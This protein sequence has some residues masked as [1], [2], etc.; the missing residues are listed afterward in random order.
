MDKTKVSDTQVMSVR[1]YK[2][3]THMAAVK[4]AVYLILL[5][6]LCSLGFPNMQSTFGFSDSVITVFQFVS[7]T[8]QLVGVLFCIVAIKGANK[9][10]VPAGSNRKSATEKMEDS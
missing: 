4:K 2:F 9:I 10:W 6:S 5:L 3:Y 8:L 7:A 1:Q